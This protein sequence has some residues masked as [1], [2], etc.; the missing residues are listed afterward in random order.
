MSTGRNG[1]SWNGE[2]DQCEEAGPA[3]SALCVPWPVCHQAGA[4]VAAGGRSGR[5]REA[6]AHHGRL[7]RRVPVRPAQLPPRR[8]GGGAAVRRGPPAGGLHEGQ[9]R[10]E[11]P[12][13]GRV[14]DR[15]LG[16]LPRYCP[17]RRAQVRGQHH[18][19]ADGTA[20]HEQP[21]QGL[22][23]RPEQ[24]CA[25]DWRLRQ[26]QNSLFFEAKSHAMYLKILSSF[27]RGD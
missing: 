18:P 17:L 10:Q 13:R 5:F 2:A 9:E 11:I 6:A 27:V 23:D 15:P 16:Q 3:E 21:P 25:G 26:R 24:E 14:R 4:G 19:D 1:G 7:F 22:Q 12:P 8:S 20:H